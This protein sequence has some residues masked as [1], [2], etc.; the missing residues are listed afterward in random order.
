M[1]IPDQ[2]PTVEGFFDALERMTGVSKAELKKLS[3]TRGTAWGRGSILH[4]PTAAID[5]HP[6]ES[7]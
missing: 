2:D 6:R 4:T 1:T 7:D 3:V 5:P